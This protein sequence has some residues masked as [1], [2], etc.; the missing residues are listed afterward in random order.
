MR[1][2]N[3][4]SLYAEY[5]YHVDHLPS[6][7]HEAKVLSV[8]LKPG[9]RGFLQSVALARAGALVY[10][11]GIVGK[12][13]AF[14]PEL[15]RKFNA[16]A[17]RVTEDSASGSHVIIEKDKS[18][19]SIRAVSP[20]VNLSISSQK[21]EDDMFFFESGDWLLLQNEINTDAMKTAM[22]LAKEKGMKIALNPSPF[23]PEI[24]ELPLKLV[25]ILILNLSEASKLTKLNDPVKISDAL[26]KNYPET[27]AVMT[28]GSDG[29]VYRDAKNLLYQNVYPFVPA[30]LT[31]RGDTFTGF[32]MAGVLAELPPEEC[33]R[34]AAMAASIAVS[35]AGSYESIPDKKEVT[36]HL[37]RL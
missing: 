6:P 24:F 37:E 5:I 10:H 14:L 9:G 18:G 36:E 21:I 12:G 17:D 28:L 23:G 7:D 32:Y 22:Y 16:D 3:Y 27:A 19:A 31:A 1:I 11:A 30:D 15:L 33:L 20:G 26:L 13:G 25:D 4:G 29:S 34:R 8:E 2:L 35:R